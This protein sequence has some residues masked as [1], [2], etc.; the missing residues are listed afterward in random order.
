MAVRIQIRRD[1][2]TNWTNNNPILAQGEL[3][4]DLANG[5]FKIGTG[6]TAWN[7]LPYF[8]TKNKVGLENVE[9]FDI[10]NKSEA[11]TGTS[12]ELYM[13]PL[14]TAEAILSQT[15]SILTSGGFATE[16]FVNNT[17]ADIGGNG[18]LWDNSEKEYNLDY[19]SN[20]D[21]TTGTSTTK[22]LVPANIQYM[23]IDGGE[24]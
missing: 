23:V 18:L 11:E 3:G 1:N 20:S 5:N 9:N 15:G 22:V 2:A 16:T 12:N 24:F 19:A 13:T 10:A 7:D 21:T 8:V 6:S 4:Y 17:V 14:R